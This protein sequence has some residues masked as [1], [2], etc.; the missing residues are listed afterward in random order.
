MKK[1]L[2]LDPFSGIAG[3]MFLG[4][5]VDLGVDLEHLKRDLS[6]MEVDFDFEVKKVNKKGITA[7]KVTVIFPGKEHH[8]DHLI[9]NHHHHGKHLSDIL[10][11]LSRLDSPLREKA[12]EM[13]EALAEAESKVHGLPREKVH[14]HE[15]GA[16]DAVVEIAGA[17]AGLKHLGVDEVLCG[18][19]NVGS[20]FVM[21]EHGRYPV[22]AP[23][24]AELLK[25]IP[26]Y[27]DQKVR[28]ELVTPTG[29][30]ILKTLVNEF[31]TP[32][33]KI[34]KIG[35]GAGTMDLE[36]PNVLRGYLGYVEDTG[37]GK[38]VLIET[39]IDDMNPQFFGYLME[40]LFDAGAKDVF[41]T[42]VYM[43]KNR[44]AIKVSVLCSVEKKDD[45]LKLLFKES[46]SIG[47]RVFY[48]EKIEALREMKVVETE[49]GKIPVKVAS[50]DSEIVN[51]APE[52]EA[53]KQIAQER[54]I[55]LKEIYSTVYKKVLEGR[56]NV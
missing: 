54:G 11:I 7:T 29:A 15:V 10:E 9:H 18:T 19:V 26:V 17:V 47:A 39:N 34:E 33:L 52:Y 8:E 12:T 2:Y 16:L 45:I 53:C 22:P 28:A 46:T 36:I 41:Y 6:K 38:D 13:F 49:Y 24:T 50:F 31:H 30:V 42:S 14:F 55:P 48:P 40:R 20:G 32:L 27:M 4:L 51:I 56:R 37:K 3:D 25:G 44:P 35:Y 43:K 1:I 23:A 5:L 21:T